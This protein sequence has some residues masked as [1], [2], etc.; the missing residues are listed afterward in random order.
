NPVADGSFTIDSAACPTGATAGLRAG[1][2][3]ASAAGNSGLRYDA[4]S[5]QY[6]FNWKTERTWAGTCR[7]LIVGTSDGQEHRLTFQFR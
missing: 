5:G 6:L 3:T 2:A 7:E 1:R 4:S